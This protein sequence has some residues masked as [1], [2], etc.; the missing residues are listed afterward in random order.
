MKIIYIHSSYSIRE[1]LFTGMTES[2]KGKAPV[3]DI[4]VKTDPPKLSATWAK[5]V[6]NINPAKIRSK[7]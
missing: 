3:I 6:L 5:L 1:A 2:K 7:L 4:H